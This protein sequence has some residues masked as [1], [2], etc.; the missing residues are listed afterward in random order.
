MFGEHGYLFSGNELGNI[1]CLTITD[2]PGGR[3][4]KS[5]SLREEVTDKFSQAFPPALPVPL[6]GLCV[7]A[8]SYLKRDTH[9]PRLKF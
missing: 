3:P 4:S 5:W 1:F 2:A 6:A 8:S 9:A 7:S